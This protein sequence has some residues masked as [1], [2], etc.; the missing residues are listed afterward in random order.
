MFPSEIYDLAAKLIQTCAGKQQKIVTAESCT[1]GLIAGAL[2][3]IPGSSDVIERGFITYSNEAKMEML[4]VTAESIKRN[5][6]VSAEVSE[7][8]ALGALEHSKA[9]I[10]VSCT[11]IAGP[12]GGT[13]SKP[14]GLVFIG[15]ATRAG[16]VFH[17][18]CFFKGDRDDVRTQAVQEALKLMMSIIQE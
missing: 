6:A 11:G 10:A 9:D 17:Y 15:I 1:G 3:E 5:G 7:A 13:P 14:V 2:T 16:A 4:D 8:M 18:K 12:D